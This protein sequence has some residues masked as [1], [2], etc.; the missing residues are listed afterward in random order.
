MKSKF[1]MIEG[2]HFKKEGY[3]YNISCYVP[4]FCREKITTLHKDT[5]RVVKIKFPTTL[6]L[7]SKNNYVSIKLI[8]FGF[9]IS[10]EIQ[11]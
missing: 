1:T 9:G 11:S 10:F 6:K 8:L 3:Y 5:Y 7:T 4:E 2:G